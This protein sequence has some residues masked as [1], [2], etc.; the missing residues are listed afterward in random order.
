M[1][2]VLHTIL[3]F[4]ALLVQASATTVNQTNADL[5]PEEAGDPPSTVLGARLQQV[6]HL[7]LG[8]ELLFSL[9]H[10]VRNVLWGMIGNVQLLQYEP[11]P[12][13]T[14][15]MIEDVLVAGRQLQDLIHSML[16]IAPQNSTARCSVDEVLLHVV[17]LA[18]PM[19]RDCQAEIECAPTADID[20]ALAPHVLQQI[21]LNLVLNS[22]QAVCREHGR[23]WL[24]AEED[25]E[26]VRL[27]VR[28]NGPG[29]PDDVLPYIFDPFYTT[30]SSSGGTGL[31]LPIARKLIREAQGELAAINTRPGSTTFELRLPRI[32]T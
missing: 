24:S 29:I 14:R 17:R 9:G 23:I 2:F 22:I 20:V 28:D 18:R 27:S 32:T 16:G 5:P 10:E 12:P 11:L 15:E 8:G 6:E 13:K 7:V 26:Y 4:V 21:V 19:V 31:G 3:A 1:P 30:K 25:A